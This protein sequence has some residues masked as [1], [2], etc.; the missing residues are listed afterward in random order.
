[1]KVPADALSGG[2]LFLA[3][4]AVFSLYPPVVGSRVQGS[5]LWV[6]SYQGTDLI[7][8]LHPHDLITS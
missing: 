8:G 7:P 5:M 4:D 2:A 1:M 3:W 6:S